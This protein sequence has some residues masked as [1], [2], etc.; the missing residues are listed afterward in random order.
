VLKILR[1]I[2]TKINGKYTIWYRNLLSEK[3]TGSSNKKL[4]PIEKFYYTYINVFNDDGCQT[5]QDYQKMTSS[6]RRIMYY[7]QYKQF[8][9]EAGQRISIY[10][11]DKLTMTQIT[12]VVL[13]EKTKYTKHNVDK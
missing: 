7:K 10:P 8:D 9:R 3:Y 4:R 6:Q 12:K 5:I 11:T 2:N 13:V 1:K